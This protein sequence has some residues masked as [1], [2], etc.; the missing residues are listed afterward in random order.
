VIAIEKCR[1]IIGDPTI[2]DN[3]IES[4][5]EALYSLAFV[6]FDECAAKPKD[7]SRESEADAGAERLQF[8]KALALMPEFERE[9]IEERAAIKEYEAEL[10][11]DE[12][13]R[14]AIQEYV[15]R[16]RSH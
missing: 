1:K 10:N 15:E 13:E 5:R 11:K 14:S 3:E 9:H 12:A 4:I 6:L 7:F 2:P 16:P 8:R